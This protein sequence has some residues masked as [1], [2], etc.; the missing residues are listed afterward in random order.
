MA[1]DVKVYALST[2]I[3][4]KNAKSFLDEKKVDYDCVFVDTLKGDDRK[5]VIEEIKKVN[6]ALS[7]P[8]MIIGGTVVIGFNKDDMLKALDI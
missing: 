6:P 7:F 3:H 1:Q 2:C 8:T 4:C 5:S